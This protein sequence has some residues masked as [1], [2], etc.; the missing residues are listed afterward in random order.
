M[1]FTE[2]ERKYIDWKLRL[3]DEIQLRNGNKLYPFEDVAKRFLEEFEI[4]EENYRV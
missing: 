3:A 1:E 2:E 4:E